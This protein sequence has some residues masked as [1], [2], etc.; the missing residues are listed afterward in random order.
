[1]KES[2]WE[3]YFTPKMSIKRKNL[4]QDFKDNKINVIVLE[5]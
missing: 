4:I 5:N 3:E 1:M 2:D